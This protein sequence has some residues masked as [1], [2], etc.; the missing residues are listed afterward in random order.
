MKTSH[1]NTGHAL[2]QTSDLVTLAIG[3]IRLPIKLLTV[4]GEWQHR[5]SQREHLGDLDDRLLKDM[6]LTR[7]DVFQEASKPFWVK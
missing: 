7:S 4:V 1:I 6:G 2:S 5:S 3:F